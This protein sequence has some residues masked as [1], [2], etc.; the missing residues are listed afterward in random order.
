MHCI[1]RLLFSVVDEK[2]CDKSIIF[3]AYAL[4]QIN[5]EASEQNLKIKVKYKANT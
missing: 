1:S 2:K 3:T 5:A 4:E